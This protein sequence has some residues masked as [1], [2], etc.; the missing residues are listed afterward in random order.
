MFRSTLL[1]S[2]KFKKMK[3]IIFI[4]I[5][6]L[7][8]S[9]CNP[10]LTE[11]INNISKKD[12]REAIYVAYPIIEAKRE[13]N[14]ASFQDPDKTALILT[15]S[16]V[17]QS[18][19]GFLNKKQVYFA[20]YDSVECKMIK[21]LV[22]S[23]VTQFKT[24]KHKKFKITQNLPFGSD[25][26]LI[27]IPYYTW[28]RSTEDYDHGNCQ[29]GGYAL[30][31]GHMYCTWTGSEG[32]LLLINVE[33]KEINYF[34]HYGWRMATIFY[35]EQRRVTRQIGYVTKPLVRKLRH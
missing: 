18:L 27:L 16:L 13:S 33:T 28:T 6:L 34:R 21:A 17:K 20:K 4:L 31:S 9:A 22:D 19:H 3:R 2:N 24:G 10:Y 8:F 12:K 15:D 30:Y 7:L 11:K 1:V 5:S 26:K 23:V 29:I 35:P 32:G 25:K 14:T